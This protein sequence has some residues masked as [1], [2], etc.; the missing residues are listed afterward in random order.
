[1]NGKAKGNGVTEYPLQTLSTRK[2][3]TAAG[4]DD[5]KLSGSILP[6]RGIAQQDDIIREKNEREYVVPF[7]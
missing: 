5:A 4:A 7:I 6:P 1:M 3:T 2:R